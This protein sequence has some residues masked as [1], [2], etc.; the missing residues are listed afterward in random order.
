MSG[1]AGDQLYATEGE[2]RQVHDWLIIKRCPTCG[3]LHGV[4][5]RLNR[6]AL[7]ECEQ[8]GIYCP[9]GHQWHYVGETDGDR[10]KHERE[11]SASLRARLDQ[12]EAS[13]KAQK[14]AATRAR[15]QRDRERRRVAGGVCPCC[16]RTF[17]NLARHMAGQHPDYAEDGAA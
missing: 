6:R 2:Q 1:S 15:N 3:V 4:P 7:E 17:K 11:R 14:A 5:S 12:T 8:G 10:L 9:N 16:N 13:L